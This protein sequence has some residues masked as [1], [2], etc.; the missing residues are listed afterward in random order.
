[1]DNNIIEIKNYSKR[2]KEYLILNHINLNIQKGKC[3]G[4]IG[5]NGSGKSML[6][7]AIC[8]L[9]KSTKGYIK[10]N[11][12]IVGK[13]VDFPDNVGM[14]IEYPG[15]LYDY[16][17]FNNL[18]YLAAINNKISEQQIID[19][20][21]L[22]ELDYKSKK[23]VK[24]Y[25]L[26]MKQRLGIAQAIME[27]PSIIILDEPMNGLDRNG[28]VLVRKI[29]QKLKQEGKTILLAS[30]NSTDI[31]LLCDKVFEMNNGTL[32]SFD[33]TNIHEG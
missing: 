1:M 30:H 5:R 16:S 8:G 32:E 17:G 9:I 4:F 25:S 3:Y 15:F 22:M 26:G 28:V 20:M 24:K 27:D 13:E 12:K 31:E 6:F 14:L 33:G 23:P 29:I 7:K 21:T 10:V 19:T 18:K 2:I 11:N